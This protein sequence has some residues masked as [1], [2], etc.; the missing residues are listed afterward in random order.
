MVHVK[1]KTKIKAAL[2]GAT[3]AISAI[4]SPMKLSTNTPVDAAANANF[5]KAL[6]YSLY[7]YDSNNVWYRSRGEKC[8]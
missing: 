3:M 5:A 6:Q 2:V 4:V 1:K 8:S 7:F